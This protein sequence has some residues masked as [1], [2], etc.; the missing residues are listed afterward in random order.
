MPITCFKD[1][2]LDVSRG[3][4]RI[5]EMSEDTRAHGGKENKDDSVSGTFQLPTDSTVPNYSS[6]QTK[7]LTS[8]SNNQGTHKINFEVMLNACGGKWLEETYAE[9]P[10]ILEKIILASKV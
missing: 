3:E 8:I 7:P 4:E 5:D 10:G 9:D 1:Q 2:C 6:R